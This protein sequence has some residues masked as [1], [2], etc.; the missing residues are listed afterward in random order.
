MTGWRLKP[1]PAAVL[2]ATVLAEAAALAL[3]WGLE[4]RGEALLYALN[5]ICLAGLGA[6]IVSQYP[7]HAIGWLFCA[8]GLVSGALMSD[9][10][11]GFGLRAAAE[12]WPGGPAGEW[13]N[14]IGW[15]V[16]GLGWI[17]T[18]LLFPDGRLISPRWRLVAWL[19][20]VGFAVAAPAWTLDPARGKDYVA[21]TN[22]LAVHGL[23]YGVLL[24]IGMLLFIG[25]LVASAASLVAR[26]R[27][28]RSDERQQIKWF[29]FAGA[30]A[31]I[32][33]PLSFALWYSVPG[34]RVLPALV[35]IV[36][37]VAAAV[38]ILRYRLYDIDRLI[39]LA[40][41]YGVVSVLL[42][43]TFTVTVLVLG[44]AFG[45]G[46]SW[47]TAGA[48]LAAA[49]AFRPLLAR[50]Q[51]AVDRHFNRT[52]YDSIRQIT[53]F[54]EDLRDGRTAPEAVIPVLRAI[55]GDPGLE[56]RFFLPASAV[57]VDSDG[58]L[59]SDD[60]EDTRLRLPVERNGQPLAVVLYTPPLEQ[61][62]TLP[63]RV[64]KAGALAIEIARL[65][66]EVR[67]QLAEVQASRARI[68]AAT[69]EERRRIER[70][71]HDGA[72]QRLVSIGLALRHAQHEVNRSQTER[73]SETLDDAAAEIAVALEE[74]REL[75]S[76]LPPSQL[77]AGIA[78]AFRELAG[79][80]PLPVQVD[81]PSERFDQ[82]VEAAAY[83]VGCEG[84]TN[85]LKHAKA[86]RILL[87]AGRQNG[88]LIVSVADDGLGGATPTAGSGLTGL[89]DRVAALG[90]TLRIVSKQ[91]AGTT[92]TAQLP[93]E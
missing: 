60:V 33:L 17:L 37:P 43:A 48:T 66:V 51:H 2:A 41:V 86:S 39:N 35:L 5:W 20:V 21:G 47:A 29:A 23:P 42:S 19:G 68:I 15:L 18:F 81:A 7:R 4:A 57:Y 73:A 50:V 85:A 13:L 88:T 67:H 26:W 31:A 44:T 77:D 84:L 34:I 63:G 89:C 70:N 12:G 82:A 83:F 56:V 9:L 79:R 16:S 10:A 49:V 71:L 74:L 22:P 76:G 32:G 65:N 28:S 8:A 30:L 24:G 72:Q 36:L 62:P 14:T 52:R 25:A 75:A 78:P 27:R 87:S 92:L 91:G 6:L 11:Q 59:V 3:S 45:R 69:N 38:A 80:S 58:V 54:L 90:G 1:L 53:G 61:D 93:C 55:V 46:S 64:V 40:L